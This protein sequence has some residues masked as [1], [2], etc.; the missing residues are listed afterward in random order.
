MKHT[1]ISGTCR[2]WIMRITS[3]YGVVTIARPVKAFA[4]ITVGG[5]LPWDMPLTTLQTDLQGPVAH[6][7]N[8]SGDHRHRHHVV[9]QRTRHWRP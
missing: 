7:V 4:A 3:A 1:K 8:Y 5:A 6:A 9:G 2:K